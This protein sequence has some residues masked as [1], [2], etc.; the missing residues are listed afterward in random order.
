MRMRTGWGNRGS[1]ENIRALRVNSIE[2]KTRE[3]KKI[4]FRWKTKILKVKQMLSKVFTYE[5]PVGGMF[6]WLPNVILY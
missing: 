6:T 3:K 4:V 5:A 1:R 2:S